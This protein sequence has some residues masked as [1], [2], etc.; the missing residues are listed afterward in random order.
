ME[1][2][3]KELKTELK[4][5]DLEEINRIPYHD[6][7]YWIDPMAFPDGEPSQW[8]ESTAYT[9]ADVYIWGGLRK[10]FKKPLILHEIIEADLV[11]HQGV[12]RR[13]AHREAEKFDRKYARS[14]L[15]KEEL[16]DYEKTRESL[17][18][19]FRD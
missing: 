19:S 17:E 11:L 16:S 18:K 10:E 13:A 2:D 8:F 15:N 4:L 7:M 14:L 5:I 1:V 9:G 12:D 6:N 3:F